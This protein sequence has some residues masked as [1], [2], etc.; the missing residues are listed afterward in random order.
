VSARICLCVC[1][2]AICLSL[3]VCL[4]F[5]SSVCLALFDSTSLSPNMA[6]T[7]N[8]DE[9]PAHMNQP[10]RYLAVFQH[11]AL[12]NLNGAHTRLP[13]SWPSTSILAARL[14]LS[15][16]CGA[17]FTTATTGGHA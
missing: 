5:L 4:L 1:L 7:N 10:P 14:G 2:C 8:K 15:A 6:E 17:P 16:L 3:S 12:V 9:T 11:Q 13:R